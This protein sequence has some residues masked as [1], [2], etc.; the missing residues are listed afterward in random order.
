MTAH[1][2]CGQGQ[3]SAGENLSWS[4]AT[5]F[6]RSNDEALLGAPKP[7][8]PA[9]ASRRAI[10][11][12]RAMLRRLKRSR[13]PEEHQAWGLARFNLGGLVRKSQCLI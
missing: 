10:T 3:R 5:S 9:V 12:K 13:L 4:K 2:R 1:Q 6:E 8:K 11:H 7:N